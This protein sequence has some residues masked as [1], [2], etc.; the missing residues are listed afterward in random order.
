MDAEAVKELRGPMGRP[1]TFDKRRLRQVI[2]LPVQRMKADSHVP[3]ALL[4]DATTGTSAQRLR[5]NSAELGPRSAIHIS[6]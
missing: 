2:D 6:E 1:S 5:V 4:L 3:A